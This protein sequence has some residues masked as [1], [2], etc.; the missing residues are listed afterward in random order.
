M[1]YKTLES[2]LKKKIRNQ[3]ILLGTVSIVSLLIF[4]V[5]LSLHS[6]SREIELIGPVYGPKVEH[7]TYQHAYLWGIIPGLLVFLYSVPVWIYHLLF[8]RIG[9]ARCGLHQITFYQ[10][11][12]HARLYVN[13]Q[14]GDVVGSFEHRTYLES[15]LPNGASVTVSLGRWMRTSHMTFSNGQKP[16]DL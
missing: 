12:L 8:C 2:Q 11:I 3:R 1:D 5:C 16:I 14:Q 15:P 7:V 9:T 6:S 10:G 13:G 4:L